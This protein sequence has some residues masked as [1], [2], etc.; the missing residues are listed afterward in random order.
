M[1]DRAVA[2]A[3]AL[4]AAALVVGWALASG[5]VEPSDQAPGVA[6]AVAGLLVAGLPAVHALGRRRA[7]V[8]TRRRDVLADLRRALATRPVPAPRPVRPVVVA[9]GTWV[10]RSDCILVRGK[11]VRAASAAARRD[12]RACPVCAADVA[13]AASD[14]ARTEVA[15]A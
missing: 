10:H 7:A 4:G 8:A 11:A 9:G 5:E 1:A 3:G 6:V 12:R 13:A 14:P 15:R 2:L